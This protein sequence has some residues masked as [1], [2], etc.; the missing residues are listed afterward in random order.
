MWTATESLGRCGA[1]WWASC[2]WAATL[3]WRYRQAGAKSCQRVLH[4]RPNGPDKKPRT[5][6][7]NKRAA[8]LAPILAE[9]QAAGITSQKGIAEALNERGIRTARGSG[10]WYH[11][12]VGRLLARLPARIGVGDYEKR[13]SL[14]LITSRSTGRLAGMAV[15]SAES[16]ADTRP[17]RRWRRPGAA[18]CCRRSQ[19]GRAS[20]RSTVSRGRLN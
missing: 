10:R 5:A 2:V 17:P 9:L 3:C 11:P 19:A 6:R 12:E 20:W 18:L 4:E 16:E 1:R 14:H 7:A 13:V 8:D 15:V